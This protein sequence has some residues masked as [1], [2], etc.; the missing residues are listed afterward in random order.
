MSKIK[1]L[2]EK[3]INQIAAGE[4][5]ERPSSVVKELME[6]SLDAKAT[7]IEV[8][9]QEGGRKL[10]KVSDDGEG[11]S[12]EDAKL[13]VLKH[14]TSKVYTVDD[15]TQLHTFGFRGEALSSMA[16]VSHFELSTRTKGALSGT[17]VKI[18]GGEAAKITETGRP[19]GTTISISNLFFNTPARLKF[20]KKESTEENH[21]V[22]V[23]T[24]YALA[25]PQV[26]FKLI[27]D[28]KESLRVSTSDFLG[29]VSAIFGKELAKSLLTTDLSANGIRVSGVVSAPTIT[30]ATREN[31]LFLLTV[32]G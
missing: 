26:G 5:V 32:D 9:V 13:A 18:K 1:V 2:P 28:G 7:W 27:I 12:P 24:N 10:L 15:L 19:E 31:M 21:I 16:S 8:E 20:M 30:K 23:V 25:F 17:M 22:S 4:V 14:A 6:N 29:R 3:V 11:M